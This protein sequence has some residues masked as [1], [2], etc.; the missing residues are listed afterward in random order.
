MAVYADYTYYTG[1]FLGTAITSADFAALALRAT[2]VIDQI[3]FGRATDD[4]DNETAIKNAMCAIAEELQRQ[5][6]SGSLDGISSESQG[7]YSVSFFEHSQR[8]KSNQ[9]KLENVA[10]LWLANTFL[11]FGGFNSGEYGGMTDVD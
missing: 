3:T 2:A 4:T 6:A 10:K 1:T 8:A 7:Q 9:S 5:D 11:L